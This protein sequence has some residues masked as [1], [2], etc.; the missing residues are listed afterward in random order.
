METVAAI[1]FGLLVLTFI[2]DAATDFSRTAQKWKVITA[3]G[4]MLLGSV[5]LYVTGGIDW[6]TKLSAYSLAVIVV[7]GLYLLFAFLLGSKS[8]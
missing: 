8:N 1:L 3:V 4:G 2:V 6:Q 5:G 7:S